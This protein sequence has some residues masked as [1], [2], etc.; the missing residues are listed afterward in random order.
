MPHATATRPTLCL[1][2]LASLLTAQPAQPTWPNLQVGIATNHIV[3]VDLYLPPVGLPPYPCVLWIHGGSWNYGDKADAAWDAAFFTSRGFAVASVSYRLVWQNTWPAQLHDCKGAVRWL[4]AHAGT[5]GLDPAR[6]YAYGP[7]AGGHIAAVLG[8]TGDAPST[9]GTI[10]GNLGY[11]S[12]VQ[13][14]IAFAAPT[15]LLALPAGSPIELSASALIGY[16]LPILA[17]NPTDVLLQPWVQLALSADPATYASSADPPFYL[18]HNVGDPVVP[19]TQSETL[20]NALWGVDNLTELNI[21]GGALHILSAQEMAQRDPILRRFL[22]LADST[23]NDSGTL[24][25]PH[26]Q[27]I[28]SVLNLAISGGPPATR[29]VLAGATEPGH[30]PYG[31]WGHLLIGTS[32]LQ[33]LSVGNLDATGSASYGLAVPANPSLTTTNYYFQ[34]LILD[35]PLTGNPGFTNLQITYI[36][37]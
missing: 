14:V 9:H 2:L 36:T 8:T 34:A 21:A 7:S 28:G 33:I 6:I 10:G 12:A 22:T 5:Y 17:A 26:I 32:T 20:A 3:R 15:D 24:L 1:L 11:S 25:A 16:S 37:L 13:G 18:A 30:G 23:I 31:R 19:S 4:R 29:F 27:S 35:H